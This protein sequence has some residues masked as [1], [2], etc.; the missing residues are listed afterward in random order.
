[1]KSDSK[2]KK[3]SLVSLLIITKSCDSQRNVHSHDISVV[4]R[5][6]KTIYHVCYVKKIHFKCILYYATLVSYC[7]NVISLTFCNMKIPTEIRKPSLQLY[8]ESK[9]VLVTI[10]FSFLKMFFNKMLQMFTK[11]YILFFLVQ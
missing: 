2:F 4:G 3:N 10:T 9:N 5:P 11:N 7:E 8:S 1:M 6:L